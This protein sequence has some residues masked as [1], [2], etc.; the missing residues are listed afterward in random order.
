[1]ALVR[2]MLFLFTQVELV[3][4]EWMCTVPCGC[5]RLV[6]AGDCYGEVGWAI[7]NLSAAPNFVVKCKTSR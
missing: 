3:N 4:G 1:M 2:E 7:G 5:W 6:V